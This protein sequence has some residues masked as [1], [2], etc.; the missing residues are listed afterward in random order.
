MKSINQRNVIKSKI[1]TVVG[2][3][4]W[5]IVL[6]C[7]AKGIMTWMWEGTVGMGVGTLLFFASDRMRDYIDD[8]KQYLTRNKNNERTD[9]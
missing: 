5:V 6:V 8:A 3:S 4:V 1:A 9:S 7:V 2:A